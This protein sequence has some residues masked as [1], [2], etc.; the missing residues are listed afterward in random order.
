MFNLNLSPQPYMAEFGLEHIQKVDSV[1]KIVTVSVGGNKQVYIDIGGDKIHN[2]I[3][4]NRELVINFTDGE[5]EI[6]L[7]TIYDAFKNGDTATSSGTIL[8]ETES[9]V[10][11]MDGDIEPSSTRL[12]VADI[13]YEKQPVYI[14]LDLSQVEKYD[15]KNGELT[16]YN[17]E[18]KDVTEDIAGVEFVTSKTYDKKYLFIGVEDV[19]NDE[20]SL[21]GLEMTKKLVTD[22]VVLGLQGLVESN[23]DSKMVVL[24]ESIEII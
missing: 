24:L 12:S 4:I 15:E 16:A 13:D 18:T 8:S 20:L 3:D 11:L 23:T 10:V 7:T 17:L 9:K 6:F 2:T 22:E 5:W 1:K 19:Y 21:S 14:E